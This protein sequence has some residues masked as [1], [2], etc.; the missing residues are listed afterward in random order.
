M[1]RWLRCG[2]LLA[3][4]VALGWSD[5]SAADGAADFF[6]GRSMRFAVVYEPGGTYDLYSRLMAAHLPRHIP[7]SPALVVQYMPGAG[8]LVGTR[9][10]ST[11]SRRR[12][13]V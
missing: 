1:L 9:S 7:G 5:R 10:T 2:A 13:A 11:K 8:D 6:K 12:T 4:C 3:M